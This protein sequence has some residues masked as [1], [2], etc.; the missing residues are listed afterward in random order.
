MPRTGSSGRPGG[1]GWGRRGIDQCVHE[2]EMPI[3]SVDLPDQ[4]HKCA[5]AVIAEGWFGSM[6]ELMVEAVRRCVESQSH[7][8]MRRFVEEDIRWGLYSSD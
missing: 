1:I 2:I 5:E 3:V 6:D 8:L 7:E 4:I